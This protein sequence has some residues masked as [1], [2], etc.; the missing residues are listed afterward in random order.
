MEET[1][2]LLNIC[3]KGSKKNCRKSRCIQTHQQ[4]GILIEEQ[5]VNDF[6]LIYALANVTG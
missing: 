6:N 3:T 5:A 4:Q 2:E 1:M